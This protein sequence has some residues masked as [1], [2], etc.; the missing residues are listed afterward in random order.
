MSWFKH[1]SSSS[2]NLL[3]FMKDLQ[4]KLPKY[5]YVTLQFGNFSGENYFLLNFSTKYFY[6]LQLQPVEGIKLYFLLFSLLARYPL[7]L[8]VPFFAV[9]KFSRSRDQMVVKIFKILHV[10]INK[11]LKINPKK[12]EKENKN[13]IVIKN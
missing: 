12:K 3:H 2:S 8:Y 13:S 1:F 7:L 6:Q 10:S 11:N 9:W 4:V 5:G